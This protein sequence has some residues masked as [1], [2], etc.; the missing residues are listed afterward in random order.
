M[1]TPC[2]YCKASLGTNESLLVPASIQ[3]KLR[4]CGA[5]G[6]PGQSARRPGNL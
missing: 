4:G 6:H 1:F 3:D 5:A 2:M